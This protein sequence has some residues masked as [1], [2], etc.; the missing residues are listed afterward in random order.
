MCGM[1]HS[2]SAGEAAFP[3]FGWV[4]LGGGLGRLFSFA[5]GPPSG[6]NGALRRAAAA[7]AARA[8]ALVALAV[9]AA[10]PAAAAVA[11]A[12]AAA[13]AAADSDSK[14]DFTGLDAVSADRSVFVG[15]SHS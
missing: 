4:A 12:A 5:E 6:S 11:A 14:F 10:A 7:A 8:A 9:A 2:S 3:L 13:A 1:L 15:S